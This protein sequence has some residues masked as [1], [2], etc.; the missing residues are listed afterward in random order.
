MPYK[1]RGARQRQRFKKSV[2]AQRILKEQVPSCCSFVPS[3]RDYTDDLTAAENSLRSVIDR[4]GR[5]TY[6]ADYLARLGVTERSVKSWARKRDDERPPTVGHREPVWATAASPTGA[7]FAPISMGNRFRP[8]LAPIRVCRFPMSAPRIGPARAPMPPNGR[9]RSKPRPAPARAL[10]KRTCRR[11]VMESGAL[12]R[13]C[14][15]LAERVVKC[16]FLRLQLMQ[17]A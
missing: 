14:H 13:P 15:R 6:G 10:S 5:Q 17:A 8:S 2:F 11:R 12:V 3:M 4:L 9:P 16:C 1:W 7:V